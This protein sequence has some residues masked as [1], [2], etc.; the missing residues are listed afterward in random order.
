[1]SSVWRVQC[2]YRIRYCSFLTLLACMQ[3]SYGISVDAFGR[4]ART[5]YAMWSLNVTYKVGWRKAVKHPG[6]PACA[7]AC[8]TQPCGRQQYPPE[9]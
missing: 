5:G 2:G 7:H 8:A 3:A 1:M 6:W 4:T 9:G